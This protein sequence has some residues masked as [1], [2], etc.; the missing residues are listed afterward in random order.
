MAT[1]E[2]GGRDIAA[3]FN[4]RSNSHELI[5]L[6]GSMLDRETISQYNFTVIARDA[7]SLTSNATVTINLLDENDN[8]PVITNDG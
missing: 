8:A 5:V 4:F 3:I 1:S 7:T 6:D 2:T